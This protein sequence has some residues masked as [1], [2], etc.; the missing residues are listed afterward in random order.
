MGLG[1]IG[2]AV[3]GVLFLTA[4]VASGIFIAMYSLLAER[5]GLARVF[6]LSLPI[7]GFRYDLSKLVSGYLAFGIPWL[8]LTAI[9]LGVFL[10]PGAER[11]M[12]VYAIVLQMFVLALFGAILAALFAVSSEGM[13]GVVI[14]VMNISFSLFVLALSQPNISGP[15]HGPTL[16]WTRFAILSLAGDAL[17]VALTLAFCLLLMSRRRDYL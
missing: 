2:F 14:I 13:S 5:K 15:L 8:A 3:G 4:D 1:K 17:L 9:A 12:I 11:G 10:L 6:A 7:S 16:V